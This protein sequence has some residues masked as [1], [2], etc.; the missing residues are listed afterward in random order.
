MKSLY[1]AVLV[2]S[3]LCVIVPSVVL[4]A[5]GDH[6]KSHPCS[7]RI[8]GWQWPIYYNDAPRYNPDRTLYPGD[9]F[10]YLFLYSGLDECQ[11]FGPGR[12]ISEGELDVITHQIY[13]DKEKSHTHLNLAPKKFEARGWHEVTHYERGKHND[14]RGH[15][16]HSHNFP[17]SESAGTIYLKSGPSQWSHTKFNWYALDKNDKVDI[18][19]KYKGQQGHKMIFGYDKYAKNK[20]CSHTCDFTKKITSVWYL[21]NVTKS[22]HRVE[23]PHPFEDQKSI[24][25]FDKRIESKCANLRENQGCVFGHSEVNIKTDELFRKCLRDELEEKRKTYTLLP[26]LNS[27]A[28][29]KCLPV[30]HRISLT[31][32]GYEI[33][34]KKFNECESIKKEKLAKLSVKLRSPVPTIHF[35]RPPIIDH[36]GHASKNLDNTYYVWDFPAL[37]VQPH[38]LYRDVRND[39]ISF[40]VLRTKTPITEVFTNAVVDA[41][42]KNDVDYTFTNVF[43]NER[44]IITVEG[45][46]NHADSITPTPIRAVNGDRLDVFWP[47][48]LGEQGIHNFPYDVRVY[49]I[50]ND[51]IDREISRVDDSSIDTLIA[52]YTP[53]FSEFHFP[54]IILNTPG[55]TTYDK[56]HGIALHYLGSKGTGPDDDGEIHHDRRAK[57]NNSTHE[58]HANTLSNKYDLESV[59]ELRGGKG[60]KDIT[61]QVHPTILESLGR[62]KLGDDYENPLVSVDNVTVFFKEGYGRLALLFDGLRAEIS[63]VGVAEINTNNILYSEK[64]GGY[65][66]TKLYTYP[67]QYPGAYL[68]SS[69]NVTA[70]TSD[71]TIDES[72]DIEVVF[73]VNHEIEKT[74][75][76]SEYMESHIDNFEKKAKKTHASKNNRFYNPQAVTLP[77]EFADMYLG[78]MHG[79]MNNASGTGMLIVPINLPAVRILS[80]TYNTFGYDPEISEEDLSDITS[81]V[82]SRPPSPDE[83]SDTDDVPNTTPVGRDNTRNIDRTTTDGGG[84]VSSASSDGPICIPDCVFVDIDDEIAFTQFGEEYSYSSPV[85]YNMTVFANGLNH[86]LPFTTYGFSQ[87]INYTIN[88]DSGNYLNSTVYKGAEIPTLHIRS[89]DNFGTIDK[90]TI[91]GELYEG[92]CVTSCQLIVPYDAVVEATNIWGGTAIINMTEQEERTGPNKQ[93][94]IAVAYVDSTVPTITVLITVFAVVMIYLR[95]LRK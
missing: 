19:Y 8:S 12:M 82:T 44:G 5:S 60:I 3:L 83:S 56:Q 22:H 87:I 11:S 25:I 39:T 71:G 72:T 28:P 33:Q 13:P 7:V 92:T 36:E 65:D 61:D 17:R 66:K 26:W 58:I 79:V 34:C 73:K 63:E 20:D 15:S 88:T 91:N 2:A 18:P 53:L 31:V 50:Y 43:T 38:L 75:H 29:N 24:D 27:Y 76:L 40:E 47:E 93:R 54:Y 49:N 32:V 1:F 35:D 48:F 41:W 4:E 37:L 10:H 78:D 6:G 9:A 16:V 51:T 85:S 68:A 67:Y 84:E 89:E 77:L 52:D 69:I 90:I 23:G 94:E 81:D 46:G 64:F 59:V 14:S 45:S 42:T 55:D 95:V 62:D 70:I 30:P 74:L 57:I 86:T 80:E 21:T